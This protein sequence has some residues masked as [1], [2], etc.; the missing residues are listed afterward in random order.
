MRARFLG[1][2]VF[3]E[4]QV[5][6]ESLADFQALPAIVLAA[7]LS[8]RMGQFKPLMMLGTRTLLGHVL[9]SLRGSGAVDEIIVVTGHRRSEVEAALAHTPG[10]RTVFNPH[11][12][13]G[14]MLSSLRAGIA[15][16]PSQSSPASPA[17]LAPAGFILAFADQPAVLSITIRVLVAAFHQSNPPIVLPTH[18]GRR[19]HPLVLSE[20]LVPEIFALS[21]TQTLRT[22][23]HQHLPRAALVP[24]DDPSVLEDLDTPVDWARAHARFA[25]AADADAGP[26]AGPNADS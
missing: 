17:R 11:Y 13:Q 19:G 4:T 20:D 23:V 6:A 12:A 8:T 3:S 24:V 21:E 7:G 1:L 14:E 18:V 26:P 9:A 16:L 22:V 5:A 2:R 15:A 25:S 10:V